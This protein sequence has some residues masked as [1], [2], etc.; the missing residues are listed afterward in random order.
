MPFKDYYPPNL[1]EHV[2]LETQPLKVPTSV[3]DIF[4]VQSAKE[5][6]QITFLYRRTLTEAAEKMFKSFNPAEREALQKLWKR[7]R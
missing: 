1:V 6:R 3:T 7:K 2:P 4:R 5:D